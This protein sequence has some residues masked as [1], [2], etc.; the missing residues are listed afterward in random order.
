M[1]DYDKNKEPSDL[2]YC[3]TINLYRWTM[4]QKVPSCNFKWVEEK[5]E[6]NEGFIKK[7]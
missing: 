4:W 5:S 3:D 6:S 7:L 2:Q 1:K